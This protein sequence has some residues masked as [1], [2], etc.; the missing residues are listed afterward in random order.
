M[1]AV[2]TDL[3]QSLLF[4]RAF[5]VKHHYKTFLVDSFRQVVLGEQCSRVFVRIRR[6]YIHEK[7]EFFSYLRAVVVTEVPLAFSKCGSPTSSHSKPI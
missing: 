3:R 1:P 7:L 2:E 5:H 6:L 4:K